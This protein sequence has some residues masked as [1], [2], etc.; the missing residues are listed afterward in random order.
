MRCL[1][2]LFMSLIALSAAD[3]QQIFS[4]ENLP[5]FVDHRH[6]LQRRLGSM[7]VPPQNGAVFVLVNGDA[8][9]WRSD[10]QGAT[11]QQ[12]DAPVSGRFFSHY[13]TS[14]DPATGRFV[15]WAIRPIGKDL[16][17][18]DQGAWFDGETWHAMG[19]PSGPHD[20]WTWGGVHWDEAG[21]RTLITKQHHTWVNMWLSLDQGQNWTEILNQRSRNVGII[22][23]AILLAGVDE[24]VVQRQPDVVIGIYRSNDR[25]ATWQRVSDQMVT[26]KAPIVWRGVAYW[27]CA[28][29]LLVSEDDGATWQLRPVPGGM[30]YGPLID[31]NSKAMVVVGADGFYQT[32]DHGRSWQKLAD[33][34]G[35]GSWDEFGGREYETNN[36]QVSF[37]WDPARRLLYATPCG[38]WAWRLGY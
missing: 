22:D 28:D 23:D 16:D 5:D 38:G 12:T 2:L 11:W 1:C 36:C 24:H 10:D 7:V 25:G 32:D 9:I 6:H 33:Y 14:L 37:G 30:G 31:P 21:P 15:V 34:F 18:A 26:G 19:K 3:W 27:C 8:G 35:G 20:G 17:Y 29:G 13:S 4:A